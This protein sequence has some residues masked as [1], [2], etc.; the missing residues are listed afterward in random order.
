MSQDAQETQAQPFAWGKLLLRVAF[1]A[2]GGLSLYF[3]LPTLLELFEQAPQLENVQWRWFLLMAGLMSGA[4]AALWALTR[5]AVP[6]IPWFVA[7]TSQLTSNA[8]VKVTPGGIVAGGA[9]YFRMLAVS[10][11]PMQHAAAALASSVVKR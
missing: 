9:F 7:A 2:I 10:G 8:A 5:I 1:L 3:F 4:F 11:V 6:G